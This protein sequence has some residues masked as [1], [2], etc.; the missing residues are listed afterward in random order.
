MNLGRVTIGIG[1]G[2]V[3][4]IEETKDI[5]FDRLKRSQHGLEPA[6]PR[7][8]LASRGRRRAVGGRKNEVL[9]FA[10][11]LAQ[12]LDTR[13]ERLDP[14]RR[15][16]RPTRRAYRHVG[17][18]AA[19]ERFGGSCARASTRQA[20]VR[21]IQRLDSGPPAP[22][23]Q[24]HG[25]SGSCARRSQRR[26]AEAADS[27]RGPRGDQTARE[28]GRGGGAARRRSSSER[29]ILSMTAPPSHS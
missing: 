8:Q 10:P 22:L 18:Q 15:G 28:T 24:P 12:A 17:A 27:A 7:A 23:S 20:G 29:A 19:H 26:E 6:S 5:P 21:P 14:A 13:V 4:V 1:L 16:L 11:A 3:H 2:R 25:G 9:R